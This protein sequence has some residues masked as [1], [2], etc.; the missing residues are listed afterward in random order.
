[1]L[2]FYR[3]NKFY[4]IPFEIEIVSDEKSLV[5]LSIKGQT[6]YSVLTKNAKE[7]TAATFFA[8]PEIVKLT[9]KWLDSY[10]SGKIPDFLPPLNYDNLTPFSRLVR[11]EMLKILCGKLL[12]YGEIAKNI[13][14]ITG[15]KPCAQ[16]V[17]QA[18]G[19]NP[20][21]IIVPCHRV[22]GAN[23][24]ITGYNG[25]IDKKI[26]LLSLEGVLLTDEKVI[27]RQNFLTP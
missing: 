25:G 23:G 11:E 19:S 22:I 24:K 27:Y 21:S 17:G 16:A 8:A 15:A 6:N 14:K 12:T 4:K 5:S 18:V 7:I 2:Y 1:M 26:A 9:T 10:F 3:L 20:I 13:S